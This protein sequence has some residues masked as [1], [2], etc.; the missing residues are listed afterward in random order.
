M[1]VSLSSTAWVL[2]YAYFSTH[3]IWRQYFPSDGNEKMGGLPLVLT[4]SV[5]P[6]SHYCFPARCR[7]QA[8][9]RCALI[10]HLE[11]KKVRGA[12]RPSSQPCPSCQPPALRDSEAEV[13]SQLQQSA[14][15]P[16]VCFRGT[17]IWG[18]LTVCLEGFE[19]QRPGV[20][21][22]SWL[23]FGRKQ[24]FIF[25]TGRQKWGRLEL[26][27]T[28]VLGYL[29]PCPFWDTWNNVQLLE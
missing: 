7:G 12:P 29:S 9:F 17:V 13:P 10:I 1:G 4:Q 26:L 18:L 22:I 11:T 27:I 28:I 8:G 24:A 15:P 21:N 5:F 14:A 6:V 19:G 3:S 16:A 25:V 23:G 2:P 20:I